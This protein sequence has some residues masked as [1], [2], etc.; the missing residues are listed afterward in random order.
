[1]AWSRVSKRRRQSAPTTRGSDNARKESSG[2]RDLAASLKTWPGALVASG[3]TLLVVAVVT[4]GVATGVQASKKV[5]DFGIDFY[6][7]EEILGGSGDSFTDILGQGKPV[8]L[9]FFGGSCPP[10]RFEMPDLERVHRRRGDEFFLLGLDVGIHFGLG[11]RQSALALIEQLGVTYPAGAPKGNSPVV[12][13]AVRSLPHTIFFDSQGE[14]YRR[15]EGTINE[16]Q[17]DAIIS[18]MLRQG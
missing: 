17:L 13:Y 10:C 7:G 18:E 14:V 15:W 9:N 1:M 2:H 3:I 5:S 4:L 12:R 11:T 16:I 6:Q 8:V